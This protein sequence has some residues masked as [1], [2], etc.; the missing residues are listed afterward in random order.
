VLPAVVTNV[1]NFWYT[2]ACSQYVNRHTARSLPARLI[3][4]LED[5]EDKSLRSVSPHRTTQETATFT[6]VIWKRGAASD[7]C[8]GVHQQLRD[9]S[10]ESTTPVFRA[11]TATR[12]EKAYILIIQSHTV[13][14]VT[15][16]GSSDTTFPG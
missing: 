7:S 4:N 2:A 15:V 11:K 9:V 5:G 3:F 6:R 1:A 12:G 16:G 13:V 14:L 10:Q 8:H